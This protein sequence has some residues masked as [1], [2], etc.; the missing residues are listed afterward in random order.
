MMTDG[1]AASQ[2]LNRRAMWLWLGVAA[3][4]FLI[5]FLWDGVSTMDREPNP[6]TRS[7]EIIARAE[8]C[9]APIER[10]YG[11]K[12]LLLS[13]ID[14]RDP[15]RTKLGAIMAERYR[16]SYDFEKQQLA[17]GLW[18]FACGDYVMPDVK[19]RD[20]ITMYGGTRR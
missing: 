14:Y 12:K 2:P 20:I 17:D 18:G 19:V 15:E 1:V 11:A 9:Q 6:I 4:V 16:R 5:L 7:A 8:F 13:Y 10:I 3:V